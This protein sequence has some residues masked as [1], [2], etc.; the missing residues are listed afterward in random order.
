VA[1]LNQGRTRADAQ[2]ALKLS[3]ACGAVLEQL[4]SSLA[5]R[6]NTQASA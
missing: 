2:V 6:S 1:I 4:E 3:G 5:A